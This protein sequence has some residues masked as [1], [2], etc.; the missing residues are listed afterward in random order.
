MELSFDTQRAI[1][2][3]IDSITAAVDQL[4]VQ[5]NAEAVYEKRVAL[6]KE[7]IDLNNLSLDILAELRKG[8]VHESLDPVKKITNIIMAQTIPNSKL[9]A[10]HPGNWPAD[11]MAALE[12]SSFHRDFGNR[13]TGRQTYYFDS[14]DALNEWLMQEELHI[15]SIDYAYSV[16]G[17]RYTWDLG[18]VFAG[19]VHL[20]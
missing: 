3:H 7:A 20:G 9:G 13:N 5:M 1:M 6:R 2:A 19:A 18:P 12:V 10:E 4:I 17:M 15:R 14:E 16:H 11:A 8:K